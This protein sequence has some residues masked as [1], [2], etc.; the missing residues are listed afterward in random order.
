MR[1]QFATGKQRK[2]FRPAVA[3]SIKVSCNIWKW[4]KYWL[5]L[6]SFLF[7]GCYYLPVKCRSSNG[8]FR[9]RHSE[10]ILTY[11]WRQLAYNFMHIIDTKVLKREIL[12]FVSLSAL[13]N[14]PYFSSRFIVLSDNKITTP[15]GK[16]ITFKFQSLC[17][18][19]IFQI[20]FINAECWGDIE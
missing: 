12:F 1:S 2:Q 8:P 15:S 11:R 13:N 4:E 10:V 3:H 6:N 14:E 16:D 20:T 17:M 5:F 18:L 19:R 9:R 7:Q